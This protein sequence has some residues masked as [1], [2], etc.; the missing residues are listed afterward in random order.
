M[1]AAARRLLKGPDYSKLS[2][3]ELA[4]RLSTSIRETPEHI[5]LLM[6]MR[7][8]APVRGGARK[9]AAKKPAAKKPAAKKPASKAKKQVKK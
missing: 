5:N 3:A 9:P 2:D 7:R 4:D 8:R 6:E 1:W